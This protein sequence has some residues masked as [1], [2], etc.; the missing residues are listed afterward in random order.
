[1]LNKNTSRILARLMFFIII[2]NVSYASGIIN[3]S[4]STY[5]NGTLLHGQSIPPLVTQQQVQWS[6]AATFNGAARNIAGT[7]NQTAINY[8]DSKGTISTATTPLQIQWRANPEVA[9][10]PLIGSNT[11]PIYVMTSNILL[12]SVSQSG[13]YGSATTAPQCS[14]NQLYT[15]W[16]FQVTI[17]PSYGQSPRNVVVGRVCFYTSPIGYAQTL[18]AIPST[19]LS[20]TL[21]VGSGLQQEIIILNNNATSAKSPDGYITAQGNGYYTASAAL[22]PNGTAYVA[23]NALQG[24]QLYIHDNGT[25]GKWF[26]QYYSFTQNFIP[27]QLQFYSPS[28]IGILSPNCNV[29]SNANLSNQSVSNAVQCMN[30]TAKIYYSQGNYYANQLVTSTQ[31]VAGFTTTSVTSNGSPTVLVNLPSSFV[32]KL[33]LI[34]RISGSFLGLRVPAG[35]PQIFSVTATNLNSQGIG[36][37][38]TQMENVGNSPAQ[39][40]VSIENCPGISAPSGISY[41]LNQSQGEEISTSIVASNPNQLISEQCTVVVNDLTGG[42]SASATVNISSGLAAK[43]ANFFSHIFG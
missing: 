31:N 38:L 37:V 35:K 29:V 42:G 6:I 3:Y 11:Q 22:S 20:S 43:I 14:T 36:T 17:V 1:M 16:D 5:L 2:A 24:N 41:L 13:M 39:F 10:Y 19:Q 27:K 9:S 4:V 21:I 25:F 12:G 32:P 26:S 8:T 15:E 28:N 18:P 40:N 30:S 33:K 7:I 34:L 23:I